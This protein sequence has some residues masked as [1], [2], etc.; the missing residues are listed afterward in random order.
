MFSFLL[1]GFKNA[2]PRSVISTDSE[3]LVDGS[4]NKSVSPRNTGTAVSGIK[5]GVTALNGPDYK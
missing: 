4:R 2:S 1:S 3:K 5:E